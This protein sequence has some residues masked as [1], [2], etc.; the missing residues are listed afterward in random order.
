MDAETMRE[1]CFL[2]HAVQTNP[3][4]LKM[5]GYPF[6]YTDVA[7]IKRLSYIL[8]CA[9]PKDIGPKGKKLLALVVARAVVAQLLKGTDFA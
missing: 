3:A 7:D 9:F 1:S 4:K 2:W 8:A 6:T 5:F